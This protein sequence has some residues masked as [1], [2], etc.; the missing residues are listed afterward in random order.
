MHWNPQHRG[1]IYDIH[2]KCW[3]IFVYALLQI[4]SIS[5]QAFGTLLSLGTADVWGRRRTVALSSALLTAG[6]LV[7]GAS[8]SYAWLMVGRIIAGGG[9]G[10]SFVCVPV[11]ISELSTPEV[12]GSMGSLVSESSHMRN[13]CWCIT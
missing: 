3:C 7:M 1:G 9:I 6:L 8:T 13:C 2:A 5:I 11:Y 10:V 12:R 4:C